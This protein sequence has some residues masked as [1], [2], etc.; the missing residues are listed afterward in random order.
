VDS[1]ASELRAA[2]YRLTVAT[3]RVP[4]VAE[5]ARESGWARADVAAALHALQDVHAIALAPGSDE[6]LMAHPFSSI[7]TPYAVT[8]SR[9]TYW[10]NCAWDALAIPAMLQADASVDARCA[11]CGA[12]MPLTFDAG[13]LRTCEGVVHFAVPP[14]CFWEN[15]AFT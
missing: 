9:A 1:R 3:G 5:L 10:A 14:A 13:G 8:T 15:V 2:I 4:R 7:P 12:P 11:D 6:I